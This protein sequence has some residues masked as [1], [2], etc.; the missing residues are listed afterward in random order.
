M[1]FSRPKVVTRPRDKHCISRQNID[2]DALRVLY[3]LSGAGY[4]SYL[5]GGSVRDLLLGRTPKDF[6]I[7]TDAHP[8]VVRRLFRNCFLVGRRFRLA[9]V[10]FGRKVIETST[11]RKPPESDDPPDGRGELYQHEDNTFGT[12]EEDARR[13]DFTVNGLF[14]DIKTFSVIDYVGGLRDLESK[15]LRCIGDPNVRFREDP[16][17]M[18]RAVRFAARLGF[19][20]D[21]S[22]RRAIRRHAPEIKKASAPRLV[23]EIMKLFTYRSSEAAFRLLW[24]FGLLSVLLPDVHAFVEANGGSRSPLWKYLKALDGDPVGA[25]ASNGLRLAVLYYPLYLREVEREGAHGRAVNRLHA[26]RRTLEPIA[27]ELQ[28]PKAGVFAATALMDLMRRFEEGSKP[29]RRMRFLEHDIFPEAL[30]LRRISLAA[31]GHDPSSLKE[32]EDLAGQYQPRTRQE[33]GQSPE[34]VVTD[35]DGSSRT[36]ATGDTPEDGT[37]RSLPGEGGGPRR[38]RRRPR[39][40]HSGDRTQ[41]T[42]GD[43]PAA[44]PA[45]ERPS[46]A[47]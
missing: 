17:R 40:R 26:A 43:A 35:D 37:D 45:S 44:P 11:F 6:D 12:P 9:H 33:D 46:D 4:I 47:G 25:D 23:D 41:N 8:N 42:A 28:L 14:Y 15:T 31:V 32:W 5:V 30:A 34:D 3:R 20:I 38:R 22:S 18:L 29:G 21:W 10:V 36:P 13:R 27:R 1:L 39:R 2:P 19:R 24:D 7:S 16:V